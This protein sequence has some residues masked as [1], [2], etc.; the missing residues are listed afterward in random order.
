M[1]R[2]FLNSN[3]P[4]TRR[5]SK[6][7]YNTNF[8]NGDAAVQGD[9]KPLFLQAYADW[10]EKWQALQG[11]NSK[12]FTLTKQT[13][14]ALVTTLR[15]TACLTEDLSINYK[16][17]LTSRLQ[18]DP[19]ELRFSKYR[20]I[21]GVRFLTG[22]KRDR[23]IGTCFVDNKF[24]EIICRYIRWRF[25]KREHGRKFINFGW[26]WITCAII[27][28]WMLKVERV[29]VAAVIAG[30]ISKVIFDK[31]KCEAC[32]TLLTTVKSD[33]NKFNYLNK[34]SRR[35]LVIPSIDLHHVSKSFAILG[36]VS[37]IIKK[38]SL[39]EQ[40]LA[41]Y[42]LSERNDYAS[43]FLY[44]NHKHLLSKV[45][46]YKYLFQQWAEETQGHSTKR[47]YSGLSLIRTLRGNFNLFELWRV[48]IRGSRSFLKYFG[49]R[50]RYYRPE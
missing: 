45:I 25:K 48:R 24:F 14:S 7:R 2:G 1:P 16:F 32:K 36:C 44:I 26:W 19:L 29:E 50:N 9:N 15:C 4:W 30:Y 22:L 6:Q 23:I 35:G 31:S 10:L 27:R 20:Q 46:T 5:N 41:E 43:S 38:S 39:P 40:K 11:H 3:L 47:Q 12:K 18:A 42:V 21:S 34:H 8:R 33:S 28:S 13:C 49:N 37:N 17:I